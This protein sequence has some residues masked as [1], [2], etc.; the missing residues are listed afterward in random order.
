MVQNI[1]VI[2]G[3]IAGMEASSFLAAKGYSVDLIEKESKLGG[4]LASWDRLFPTMRRGS[5]VI[6]FL[7]E[8]INNELVTVHLKTDIS[9]IHREETGFS[10][11]T[12]NGKVL[13]GGALLLA[14]GYD[15]FDARRKEEYGYGIYNNVVTS[16]DLEAY[17]IDEKPLRT[18]QGKIPAR[19]GLVHCVGSRDEKAGHTY[20]SKVCCVTGVKQ[21]I[22]IKQQLPEAEIF[23]FYM[24]LR[25]YGMHFEALYKKA[26]EDY[27][28]QFVRGRLSEAAENIDGSVALKVEDTLAGRPMKINVDLL[29][30]L[31]G[32]VPSKGTVR[33]AEMLN[34]K[35]GVNGFFRTAD[36][37]T[38]TNS[39]TIPGVFFAGTCIGP[40]S[41][42]NA[43]TDARA[44]TSAIDIYLSGH[45][46]SKRN[47][48]AHE[49]F[50]LYPAQ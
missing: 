27:N 20:C 26:Q 24:D 42:T 6:D 7:A 45:Q 29:V 21:A 11:E 30:L 41:I 18:A 46:L 28:V 16:A 23:N 34:M 22:E 32:F 8:G 13:K 35:L 17:F 3:G 15:L 40:N 43:I 38:M 48:K 10:V 4:R 19:I 33:I 5:E 39:S 14:T 47:M 44:A 2:G 25:M 9:A 49:E 31:V 1:I 12:T 37:H 50:W 36:Q